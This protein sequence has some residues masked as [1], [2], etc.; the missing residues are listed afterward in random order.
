M[1]SGAPPTAASLTQDIRSFWFGDGAAG[2]PPS[3]R[4]QWTGKE[5][6]NWIV[7]AVR[8]LGDASAWFK[9]AATHALQA[10]DSSAIKFDTIAAEVVSA[11]PVRGCSGVRRV[12]CSRSFAAH[13]VLLLCAL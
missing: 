5:C 2:T 9:A 7:T 13:D 12:P 11:P 4:E 3:G 6:W 10:A 8:D 1:Y